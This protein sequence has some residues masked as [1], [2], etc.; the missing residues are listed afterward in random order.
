M[1]TKPLLLLALPLAGLLALLVWLRHAT[2]GAAGAPSGRA[3]ANT[4]AG[5]E[6]PPAAARRPGDDAVPRRRIAGEVLAFLRQ[7]LGSADAR[8]NEGV[9]T[10]AS[11]EA[12]RKFLGRAGQA[13][14]TVLGRL[15]GLLTVRVRYDSLA[16]LAGDLAGNLADYAAVG[17]N[18]LVEAPAVPPKED[19]AP[20]NQVPFGN[21]TLAFLGATGDRTG[22]GRGV[23]IAVLDS[24]VAPDVTFAPGQVRS[25]DLGLGV[26]PG[27]GAED[28][29]GTAVA[30][31]AGGFAADA[32]GVAPSAGILSLR[33][34]DAS[35]TSDLFTLAQAIV[36]AVDAGAQILNISMGGYDT[37]AVLGRAIDYA[38][39]HGAVIVAAAG[40][41]QAAELTWP[42]ADPRVV[43]VG[44][45]DALGQQVLFSNS[46]PQLALA[47]P[48]YGVQSAWLDG[49]RVTLD[50]TSVSAPLVAGAI[51]AVMSE[52]PGL[53]AT[54]AWAVLR[55]YAD[56][57][58]APGPDDAFGN[59]VLDLGWA[60]DHADPARTDTAVSSHYYDAAAGEMDFVVQ[61][62]GGRT[63]SGLQLQV[64]AGGTPVSY[65]L[66]ALQP[67]A[68]YVVRQPVDP[69]VL[70]A[71]GS[72]VF[73]SQLVN[74]PGLV[75]QVPANNRRAS[76]LTPAAA[77]AA[78]N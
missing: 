51:A 47:A 17:A 31:L 27:A 36:T 75:D 15:D 42:A 65:A 7:K 19:R 10:F 12:Y 8:P 50:G 58:G 72:L 24:G 40:N 9:L 34:T 49:Q 3:P 73:R 66:P 57:G 6:L 11:A 59:G 14:L 69:A 29:H 25:I 71:A 52:N 13:G 35:G 37:N 20:V 54:Q 23:T 68:S 48:G 61:N 28:G 26:L 67:G 16:G 33:V 70:A 77:P 2:E 44:A 56:D 46:G 43:S 55:Q 74:P 32:P 76:V 63:V 64:E 18:F 30:A 38:A 41:D 21:S 78:G 53:S 60:M 62:R 45:V 1:K 39:A 4:V 5:K 22:W